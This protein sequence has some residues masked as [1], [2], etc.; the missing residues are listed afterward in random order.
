MGETRLLVDIGVIAVLGSMSIAAL[1]IIFERYFSIK[2]IDVRTFKSL[3]QLE[4]TMTQYMHLLASIGSNAPYVGMLGTVLGIMATF[5][6]MG[7]NNANANGVME[8]LS[9]ALFATALG[10]TVAIPTIFIYNLLLRSV[11]NKVVEWKSLHG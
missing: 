2:Q 10:L 6:E 4:N 7:A 9:S 5:H 11:K 3:D 8:A 1:T